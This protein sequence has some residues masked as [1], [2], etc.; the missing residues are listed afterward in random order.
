MPHLII[1]YSANVADVADVQ[2]LVDVMHDAAL[3]TG[4]AALDALR[5]RAV[6][7]DH[8]AIADRDPSNKFIAISAR[9]GAGRSDDEI[10]AFVA[11]LAGALDEFLGDQQK[12]IMLSVEYQEIDPARRIN[13]NN[14]RAVVADRSKES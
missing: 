11:S 9:L 13:K 14:L 5:T 1:E 8:Y 7:R 6:A 2:K 4:T 10:D 12:T 3:A